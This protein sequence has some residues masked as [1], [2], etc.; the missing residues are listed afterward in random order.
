MKLPNSASYIL[1]RMPH[2]LGTYLALTG[3]WVSGRDALRLNLAF[4]SM[5]DFEE[6]KNAVAELKG[7][8]P[9]TA[10]IYGNQY[11]QLAEL[12]ETGMESFQQNLTEEFKTRIVTEDPKLVIT[13]LLYKYKKFEE[14]NI[15][16]ASE[17]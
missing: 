16:R 4:A 6:A 14:A 5:E 1:S 2:E 7:V 17:F 9:R 12:F 15:Y 10:E 8:A 3:R 11:N 13:E